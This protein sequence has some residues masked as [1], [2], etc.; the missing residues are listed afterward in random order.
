MRDALLTAAGELEAQVK[1]LDREMDS[2][3]ACR[4]HAA[5]V[6]K[7]GPCNVQ[8]GAQEHRIKLRNRLRRRAQSLRSM[9]RGAR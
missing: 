6:H 7:C 2:G 5:H 4:Q 8:L 9:A 1:K 3:C